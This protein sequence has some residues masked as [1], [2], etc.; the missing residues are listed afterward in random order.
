MFESKL[1]KPHIFLKRTSKNIKTNA[2]SIYFVHLWF[3]NIDI[4]FILDPYAVATYYTSYM[5]K[6]DQSITSELHS[7]I[8]KCIANTI[9]TN[10]RF[11]KLGNVFFNA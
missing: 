11:Q 10:T 9:D 2:F 5:T 4:Q 8:K 6:I 3:A 1:T 7:I